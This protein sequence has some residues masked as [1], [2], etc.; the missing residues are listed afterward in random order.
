MS[1]RTAMIPTPPIRP[2]SRIAPASSMA[3]GV[4]VLR[5]MMTATRIAMISVMSR[6]AL[7]SSSSSLYCHLSWLRSFRLVGRGDAIARERWRGCEVAEYGRASNARWERMGE[8][9]G[10][11]CPEANWRRRRRNERGMRAILRE[12]R[13]RRRRGSTRPRRLGSGDPPPI[14]VDDDEACEGKA[15]LWRQVSWMN[16]ANFN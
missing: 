2:A 6:A 13:H 7:S 10:I 3:M 11:F 5:R 14:A 9:K 16:P 12:R 15:L 8:M 4:R 1:M